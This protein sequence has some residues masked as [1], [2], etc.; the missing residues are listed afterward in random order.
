[1]ID[2][3]KLKAI[4]WHYGRDLQTV[5]ACA[6]FGEAAASASRLTVARL[7][8]SRAYESIDDEWREQ[9]TEKVDKAEHDLAE[10]CADCLVMISQLRLL[11]PGFSAKV[12]LAM[13]EK[14]ERQINRIS[15]EQQC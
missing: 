2:E 12:D 14:I 8:E 11:I 9:A 5:K 4:A 6:E 1:M 13:H 3:E 10:E 15:K 7:N